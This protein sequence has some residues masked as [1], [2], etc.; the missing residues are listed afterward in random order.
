MR[1][2]CRIGKGPTPYGDV[3]HWAS[4]A[5][6]GGGRQAG[7]SVICYIPPLRQGQPKV[8]TRIAQAEATRRE[9]ARRRVREEVSAEGTREGKCAT[10]KA[11]ADQGWVEGLNISKEE[12]QICVRNESMEP[13][14]LAGKRRHAAHPLPVTL[15]RRLVKSRGP[16]SGSE[17]DQSA[18]PAPRRPVGLGRHAGLRPG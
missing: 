5:D 10:S 18:A 2:Q 8:A 7:T 1:A 16:K 12:L 15:P 3:P 13:L 9:G 4:K 11:R 6:T 14:W 17:T